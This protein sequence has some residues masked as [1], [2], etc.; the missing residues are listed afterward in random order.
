MRSLFFKIF[1]GFCVVV[2]LVGLSIETSSILANYYE[3]RWQ[4]VLHSIM[5]M[6]AEKCARMYE[7]SGKLAVEDYLKALQQQKSVRFY[8]FDEDGNPLLDGGTPD[9]I[10][11]MARLKEQLNETAKQNLSLV[12]PRQGLAMRLVEGP[13]G[14]KY[15]LA[16]QQSPR[17]IMPVSEAVGTHP[18]LRLLGIGVFGAVLCFLLTRNITKPIVNLRA[19]ASGIAAGRLK[20]RVDPSVRRRHDEIGTLGRDFD[21]MAEQIE[22]LVNAQRDLLGDVSHELR[23]PLARLT[24]ALG[25]LRQSPAEEAPEHLNRIGLE[26]DRLDKLIGQLLT[27]TRIESGVEASQ[28]ET[29]DLTNLLQ[30]VAADGDFEARAHG[31]EVKIVHADACIMSGVPEMLRSAIENVVRNAIRYTPPGTSVDLTLEQTSIAGKSK[32]LVRVRDHGFGV[33]DKMLS[34]IFVPFYRV[35][36][37]V[38]EHTESDTQGAGLGLAI[39]ERVVR[40]HDGSIRARNAADGGLIVEMELPLARVGR[41]YA[42]AGV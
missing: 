35:Q 16:F 40:M 17:R 10:L 33:P 19:A 12:N 29:F 22:A 7:T 13:S 34:E 2:V 5:P 21:R 26:A 28:R 25:L 39:A 8:F 9:L 18:Y 32:A 41:G 20:T 11:K 36:E 23:S 38:Q 4:G 6:E 37:R 30:E 31:R 42:G 1:F 14:R 24:V 3:M 15:N 27:L